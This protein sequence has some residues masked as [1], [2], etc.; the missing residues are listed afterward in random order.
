MFDELTELAAHICQAPMAV[1]SLVDERRQWFKSRVGLKVRE[2]PREISFCAHAITQTDV[3]VVPDA[4]ADER[5]ARSPLVTKAPKIRFYAGAPLITPDGYALGALCVVDRVPRQLSADQ[6]AA[7]RIL[8]RHVVSQLELRRRTRELAEERA[9]SE[10][11]RATLEQVREGLAEAQQALLLGATP[12]LAG[13]PRARDG[14]EE[15]P[16]GAGLGSGAA[17]SS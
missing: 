4:R 11:L 12:D 1:I 8:A 6:E 16:Q 15:D 5:F 10:K 2:T 13:S 7:L 3:F 9:A 14:E 17:G